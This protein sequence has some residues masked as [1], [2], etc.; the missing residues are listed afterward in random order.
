MDDADKILIDDLKGI[1]IKV[2]SI[3]LIDSK[4]LVQSI[5]YILQQISSLLGRESFLDQDKI[6]TALNFDESSNK[7][8]VCQSL[9]SYLKKLGYYKEVNFNHFFYPN[10]LHTRSILSFLF[11]FISKK[12][13]EA[14]MAAAGEASTFND[15]RDETSFG[16][17]AKRA[18]D[19]W[20]KEPWI[21]PEF[22][23]EPKNSFARSRRRVNLFD[24]RD[25]NNCEATKSKKIKG[26]H[27][28]L[29]QVKMDTEKID[30]KNRS[31]GIIKISERAYFKAY[32]KENNYDNTIFDDDE[33]AKQN[34]VKK[35]ARLD[36]LGRKLVVKNVRNINEIA[37]TNK[38]KLQQNIPQEKSDTN[39]LTYESEFNLF[40]R[41]VKFEQNNDFATKMI[42]RMREARKNATP[43]EPEKEEFISEEII[44]VRKQNET[45]MKEFEDEI[46]T[47]TAKKFDTT[48][49]ARKIE[50]THVEVEEKLKDLSEE[51]T[52]KKREWKKK[53][54]LL[55]EL[56][57]YQG[58]DM[59]T[60]DQEITEL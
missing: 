10:I 37:R 33:D 44:K 52:L 32:E 45:Q 17:L 22:Q 54:D 58:K 49:K 30:T 12:E 1:G 5:G 50:V 35:Q 2:D 26:T 36:L 15:Q 60:L 14:Q 4:T 27:D 59:G 41:S 18:L 25:R 47:I 6:N 48:E 20:M 42:Q 19:Q 21:M 29:E 8:Q 31:L 51:I 39:I 43:D 23:L 40:N 13:E 7:F 9:I 34:L 28:Y 55:T 24:D 3:Q 16:F 53:T 11:E 38:A 57:N 56:N 46:E